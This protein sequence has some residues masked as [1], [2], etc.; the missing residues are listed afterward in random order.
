[1][2]KYSKDIQCGTYNGYQLHYRHKELACD[3]CKAAASKYV[4]TRY[5]ANKEKILE[6]QKKYR[7]NN[8]KTRAAK[9]RQKARR[10]AKQLGNGYEKYSLEKVLELYGTKCN[11]CNIEIDMKA[12][13]NCTGDNWAFG[14]HIDHVVP[15]SKGG[16]DTLE[17]V[18]PTHALCNVTKSS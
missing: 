1:M 14:L 7:R 2:K 12:P 4:M 6:R 3:S 11:I 8:P 17:N 18:R 13:R 16:S 5:F 10:R 15:I 9:N